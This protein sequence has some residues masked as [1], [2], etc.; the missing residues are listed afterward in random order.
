MG[1]ITM[2]MLNEAYLLILLIIGTFVCLFLRKKY[3]HS[4]STMKTR[5]SRIL[6]LVTLAGCTHDFAEIKKSEIDQAFILN[7]SP[8]F[9]GYYYLGSDKSYHYFSSR[10]KY[11]R[12]RQFKISKSDMVVSGER[13]FGHVEIRI[14]ELKPKSIVVEDFCKIGNFNLYVEKSPDTR[15]VKATIPRD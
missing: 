14:Y 9:Q 1:G 15:G 4:K 13:A 3:K 10:W 11:G 5:L 2:D 6:F 12:D 8:T 7:S